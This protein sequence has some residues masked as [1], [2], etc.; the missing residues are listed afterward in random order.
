[1]NPPHPPFIYLNRPQAHS[2]SVTDIHVLVHPVPGFSS[3][4]LTSSLD[5]CLRVWDCATQALHKELSAGGE[6]V[7]C[8]CVRAKELEAIA[9]T[10]SGRLVKFHLDGEME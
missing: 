4:L 5:G 6:E 3:E 10:S 9:G 7:R 8:F 2:R 1:M